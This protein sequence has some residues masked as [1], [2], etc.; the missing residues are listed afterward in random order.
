SPRSPRPA[1]SAAARQRRSLPPSIA[2]LT[3][4]LRLSA[5]HGF[6]SFTALATTDLRGGPLDGRLRDARGL[7]QSAQEALR[8]VSRGDPTRDPR[9]PPRSSRRARGPGRRSIE[10][11]RAVR[12][13]HGR[14]DRALLR[15]PAP[16][17]VGRQLAY[18]E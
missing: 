13:A 17:R 4:Y 14:R 16:Q 7:A 18:R 11:A 2:S 3:L 5:E 6:R 15:D 9:R 8:A 10:R 12:R 1:E